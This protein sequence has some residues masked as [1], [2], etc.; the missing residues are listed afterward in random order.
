MSINSDLEKDYRE[1]F[2]ILKRQLLYLM[3]DLELCSGLVSEG[4]RSSVM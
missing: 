3:F 1:I 4:F 2:V